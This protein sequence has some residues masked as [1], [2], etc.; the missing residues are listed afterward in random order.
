MSRFYRLGLLGWPL[1]HSL[2]PRLHEAALAACGLAGEYLLY[3]VP[4][5]SDVVLHLQSFLERLHQGELDGLNVTIPHKQHALAALKALQGELT[6][7]AQA[8]GAVNTLYVENGCLMG[9]NT[10]ADGFMMDLLI[11]LESFRDEQAAKRTWI[12]NE[13]PHPSPSPRRSYTNAGGGEDLAPLSPPSLLGR[14]RGRGEGI[15]QNRAALVL[16]A[17]GSARAVTY[18]LANAGWQVYLASRREEQARA[19]TEEFSHLEQAPLALAGMPVREADLPACFWEPTIAG[20]LLVNTTPLG[21]HPHT[22]ASPWPASLPFPS[23]IFVYD[24]VY[25]PPETALLRQARLAGFPGANGLGMLVGQA[26]LAFLRWTGLPAGSLSV[27][28]S[29]MRNAAF[30]TQ[31]K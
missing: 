20:K 25:N 28:Q 19:L 6:P 7:A 31:S 4:P 27:V 12:P 22:Q 29:A 9:D 23:G 5:S 1:G 13:D 26:A 21:M 30:E 18:A 10:D 2:S 15:G 17:G 16:G 11:H 3:P 14:E 8:I 24:L